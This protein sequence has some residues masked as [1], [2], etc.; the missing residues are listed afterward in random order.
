MCGGDWKLSRCTLEQGRC[1]GKS[2]SEKCLEDPQSNY[3]DGVK[4]NKLQKKNWGMREHLQEETDVWDRG[5]VQESMG[6]S[7]A[8]THS[9]GA[10]E[11]E[12][13]TSCSQAGTPVEQ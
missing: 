1:G 5:G 6:V 2:R 12:K 11:P 8:V 4:E 3:G 9:I 13:A 7:L 10:M